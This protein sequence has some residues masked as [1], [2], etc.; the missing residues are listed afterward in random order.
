MKEQENL[1]A[2]WFAVKNVY[3]ILVTTYLETSR[4]YARCAKVNWR[5]NETNIFRDHSSN[6]RCH[7]RRRT[8]RRMV[9]FLCTT[10]SRSIHRM[11]NRRNMNNIEH[12]NLERLID[13]TT[14]IN[15][16]ITFS[17]DQDYFED[18]EEIL[19]I[20]EYCESGDMGEF[21]DACLD[22]F[23]ATIHQEFNDP[24]SGHSLGSI[25]RPLGITLDT[26][27]TYD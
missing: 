11:E 16:K 2:E 27:I 12:H 21:T 3:G 25:N 17:F 13:C 8:L 26:N 19:E 5:K 15:I 7:H 24:P 22:E 1:Y 14:S 4:K 6:I 18:N 10:T 9:G 23:L 20:I